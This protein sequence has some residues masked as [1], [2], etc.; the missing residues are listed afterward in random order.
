MAS[1]IT[2]LYLMILSDIPLM[3]LSDICSG[4][5]TIIFCISVCWRINEMKVWFCYSSVLSQLKLSK[6]TGH[7]YMYLSVLIHSLDCCRC[8]TKMLIVYQ[9]LTWI[10]NYEKIVNTLYFMK[11]VQITNILIYTSRD[12]M[13]YVSQYSTSWFSVIHFINARF[14]WPEWIQIKNLSIF[15]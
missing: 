2:I 8:V 13:S 15:C 12:Q 10:K 9:V 14:Y 6:S 11:Y 3:I 4:Q 7:M 5:V 1:I